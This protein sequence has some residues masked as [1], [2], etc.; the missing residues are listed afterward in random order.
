MKQAI[1][2]PHG[3]ALAAAAK[4]YGGSKAEWLDLSTGINPVSTPLPKLSS[5]VWQALPDDDNMQSCLDAAR[6]FYDIPANAPLI[7]APGVQAIIQLL[8]HLRPGRK[9][10]ILG[11]TYG[12]YAH[13]FQTLGGGCRI[14][15]SIDDLQ[16]EA[17]VIAVN[18]N[19]PDGRV[20][21]GNMLTKLA[22]TLAT[23]SA[24]LIVD[25]AFCDLTPELSV[26][27]HAGMRGL[28]VLKSFGKFFGLAGVRL[29]FAAGHVDDIAILERLL[30]PWAVS[31]PA[32][33][34]GTACLSDTDLRSKIISQI[35]RNSSAQCT[36]ITKTGLNLMADTGLFHLIE[37]SGV[38]DIYERLAHQRI[39][40]RIF[41][42][43]P[44]WLR[45]GLC[46]NA[47]ERARLASALRVCLSTR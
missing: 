23:K 43:Q 41:T 36:L 39:L 30:G 26:A 45:L 35:Q 27:K 3:G 42:D 8:P 5:H 14:I 13:V 16:D 29:G 38:K 18:P 47:S 25:E 31:G 2:I 40:T 33:A 21:L 4:K 22:E 46:K 34:I 19:N 11:P 9:A 10:A 32:L 37:H 15:S 24:L 28:L 17:F 6:Y 20:L 1:A 7:A 12:E 44:K